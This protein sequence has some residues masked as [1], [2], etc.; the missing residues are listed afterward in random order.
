MRR[1]PAELRRTLANE[2]RDEVVEPLA[3]DIRA[4]WTGPHARALSAS[5]KARV[6]GDPKIVVGGARRVVSG[7]A[8][9]RQL[10]FG[11]E[12]GGGKRV[13]A[14]PAR[15]A[16]RGHR[17]HTTRQFPTTG[18]HTVYGTIHA[19]L[20]RTFDRWADVVNRIIE[21]SLDRG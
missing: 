18:Q 9:A 3:A 15:P 7:G 19:T 12:W 10:V 4:A 6:S 11:N 16:R 14:I 20:D 21:R 2:V 8:S 1:L 5:T 13:K 17:R